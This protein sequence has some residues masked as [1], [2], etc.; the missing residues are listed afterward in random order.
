[1]DIQ[2]QRKEE[3]WKK[4]R[5][6]QNVQF[7]AHEEEDE[8][9]HHFILTWEQKIG[10]SDFPFFLIIRSTVQCDQMLDLKVAKNCNSCPKWVHK[11][12]LLK[13]DDFKS[14]LKS[15]WIFGLLYKV[16]LLERTLKIGQSGH[17]GSA[18]HCWK[19]LLWT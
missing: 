15:H 10:I 6:A 4:L 13:S 1:M 5:I 14:S 17:T 16:N 2:T 11:Q 12:F 8:I 3:K 7:G 9:L 18:V 19:S